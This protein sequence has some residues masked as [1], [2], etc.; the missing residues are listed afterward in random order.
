M[1]SHQ[2]KRSKIEAKVEDYQNRF[3]TFA[4]D[5][6]TPDE[7]QKHWSDLQRAFKI[8]GE[9]M[10]N[11]EEYK[12]ERTHPFYP[13]LF[14][15]MQTDVGFFNQSTFLDMPT[16]LFLT[17]KLSPKWMNP[18]SK[19]PQLVQQG[20]DISSLVNGIVP[21]LDGWRKNH[22]SLWDGDI[23]VALNCGISPWIM[24][25]EG[26][27]FDIPWKSHSIDKI[28][29]LI[30]NCMEDDLKQERVDEKTIYAFFDRLRYCQYT[31]VKSWAEQRF[32]DTQVSTPSQTVNRKH[33]L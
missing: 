6:A 24:D 4:W 16:V 23:K 15:I 28:H 2:N 10:P 33:R 18:H 22:Q 14:N 31:Q 7:R 27:L 32:L 29:A 21:V 17:H 8:Q 13:S 12:Y 3:S 25:S 1:A 5:R 30:L 19:W 11:P 9:L 20:V 26:T